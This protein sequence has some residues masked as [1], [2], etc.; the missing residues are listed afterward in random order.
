MFPSSVQRYTYASDVHCGTFPYPV[1]SDRKFG[2]VECNYQ[3]SARTG[4][5][6]G[7]DKPMIGPAPPL[8]SSENDWSTTVDY[9]LSNH[10]YRAYVPSNPGN[11]VNF[12]MGHWVSDWGVS[13]H[14][15]QFYTEEALAAKIAEARYHIL[16]QYR[17]IAFHIKN[18]PDWITHPNL[19]TVKDLIISAGLTECTYRGCIVDF[20]KLHF[21][22]LWMLIEHQVP[23]HYQWFPLQSTT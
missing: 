10:P 18:R 8:F 1:A 2:A 17:F 9:W 4:I 12:P 13:N 15:D 16:E 19:S 21:E 7:S 23:I 3:N 6:L 20:K 11:N 5:L 22:E 14:R